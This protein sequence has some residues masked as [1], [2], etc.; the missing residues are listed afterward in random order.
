MGRS[1][2]SSELL[3]GETLRARLAEGAIP[4]RK[5]VEY[6]LQIAHGLA[7]AHEKGIVH[8]DLKPEN[9]FVTKPGSVKIL[10]FGLARQSV[11][12][13]PGE[14]TH[15]P[16]VARATDPGTVL[17]TVGY[18]SPE[19]VRGRLADHRSDIF[20][21]GCILY[22][23]L[24]GRRAF[25]GESPAETMA[26]IARDD[27]P[28]LSER[29]PGIPP[30]LERI[31]RHCLEKSPEERF[32]SARDLAFDLTSLSS[33]SAPQKTQPSGRAEARRRLGLAAAAALLLA[34]GVG[35]GWL[36]ASRSKGN[37]TTPATVRF[38]Q[39]TDAPGEEFSPQP[40]A[41]RRDASVRQP[42]HR[43]SRHLLGPRSGAA[44]RST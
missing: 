26:S 34:A 22:E 11:F 18:M 16:T 32:Q 44:T 21:F 15:S 4:A 1:T 35:A 33:I 6:A 43:E 19:Q 9:V 17:G 28:E 27:P 20:S 23:M 7:A 37:T 25:Q 29:T 42:R 14:D 13:S 40:L 3:E 10:D 8:R 30:G 39:L 5:A 12:V 2:R 31:V 24:S 41:G 38:Q 36:W